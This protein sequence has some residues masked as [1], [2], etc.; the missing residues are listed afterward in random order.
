MANKQKRKKP[1]A[2]QNLP[3]PPIGSF[4]ITAGLTK[5]T[6]TLIFIGSLMN[7]LPFLTLA[8]PFPARSNFREE[9]P[10]C[11]EPI[12]YMQKSIFL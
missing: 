11:Q 7:Y 12:P 6:Q 3:V 1:A 2:I 9:V 5:L 8:A 10:V 4:D